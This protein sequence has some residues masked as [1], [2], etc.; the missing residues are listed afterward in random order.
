MED[1]PDRLVL[2]CI[3]DGLLILGDE[4]KSV[5]LWWLET[6]CHIR[7]KEI[8]SRIDEFVGLLE[9]LFGSGAKI[10]ERS[11]TK[12]VQRAFHLSDADATELT[13]AVK[14]ARKGSSSR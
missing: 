4:G 7:K 1:D 11:I 14:T 10:I 8:P 3:E 12:E 2:Q 5:V 6:K 9:E 13:P